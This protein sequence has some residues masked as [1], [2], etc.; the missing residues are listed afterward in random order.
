V[1]LLLG[2]AGVYTTVH[3]LT[4]TLVR[5]RLPVDAVLMPFAAL[6]MVRLRD[7]ICVPARAS[8]ENR[9]TT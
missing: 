6:A 4:W 5:Y 1:W 2:V 9:A 7:Q 3:V 8:S